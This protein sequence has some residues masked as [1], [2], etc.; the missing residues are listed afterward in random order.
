M[1][2]KWAITIENCQKNK[3]LRQ[4]QEEFEIQVRYYDKYIDN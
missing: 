4:K 2:T 3:E 1:L